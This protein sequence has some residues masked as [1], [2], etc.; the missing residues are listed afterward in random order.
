MAATMSAV[1][2]PTANELAQLEA[3]LGLR[4]IF[5][6]AKF[7]GDL[8]FNGSAPGS[9]LTLLG[10]DGSSDVDEFASIT[11]ADLEATMIGWMYS[12]REQGDGQG[13]MGTFDIAPSPIL[14]ARVRA[15][16]NAARILTG[17]VTARHTQ[18]LQASVRKQ[19][20]DD[21]RTEKLK[22]RR[23]EA[24]PVAP[25]VPAGDTV[26]LHEIADTTKA[27]SVPV[28]MLITSLC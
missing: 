6:W 23:I 2:E 4:E 11:P 27:R 17:L 26:A 21:Y 22:A 15:A 14:K 28:F 9:L 20:E 3:Q 12:D 10:A 1:R 5:T 7:T 25:A 19:E 8:T 13:A 24:T 16:H 18:A